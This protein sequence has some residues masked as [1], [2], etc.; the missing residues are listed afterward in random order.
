MKLMMSTTELEQTFL[1]QN[2]RTELLHAL[3]DAVKSGLSM[4]NA[5]TQWVG[6]ATVPTHNIGIVTGIIG[7]HGNASGF[8]TVNMA[9]RFAIKAVEGMLQEPQEKLNP[10][11]ID[12]VG[13]ITNLLAGGVKAA[14]AGTPWGFT[15]ITAPSVIVGTGSEIAFAKGL[16]YLCATFEHQDP[17]AVLM[18]DRLLQISVSLLPA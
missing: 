7:V 14:L 6:L 1:C 18:A 15:H 17:E 12:G 13:E 3:L 10:T 9:E 16:T 4:C 2:V 5:N 8:V 11:V